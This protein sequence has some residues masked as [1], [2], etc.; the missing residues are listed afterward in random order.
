MPLAV[1]SSLH[2]SGFPKS[3]NNI[4]LSPEAK[5]KA[6]AAKKKKKKDTVTKAKRELEAKEQE[7]HVSSDEDSDPNLQHTTHHGGS[8]AVTPGKAEGAATLMSLRA[9]TRS[10]LSAGVSALSISETLK[11][12]QVRERDVSLLW[13]SKKI[14]SLTFP[15]QSSLEQLESRVTNP[16]PVEEAG[17]IAHPPVESVMR[18]VEDGQG[19]GQ[20][21][22][23]GKEDEEAGAPKELLVKLA[24]LEGERR[25]KERRK[26]G[27]KEESR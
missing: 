24:K 27:T 23:R 15:S 20:G 10:P 12:Y 9:A 7:A 25:G 11:S 22:G 18:K 16:P 5:K 14:S 8:A 13:F 1:A 26:G 3:K 21:Q 4:L 6:V 2:C 19:Q 17:L